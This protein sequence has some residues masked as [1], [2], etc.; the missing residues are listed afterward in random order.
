M[1]NG[2]RDVTSILWSFGKDRAAVGVMAVPQTAAFE[3]E[4]T[5]LVAQA[6]QSVALVYHR[7]GNGAGV[8]WRPDGQI[9]TN[10]HVARDGRVDV[11]LHDGRHYTGIVAA[12]HQTR[13]LAVIKI[14]EEHLPA[15]QIGDSSRVRPGQL[16]LAVGHPAGYR[17]AATLGVVVAAG[18]AATTEGPRTGDFLQADVTIMPGNSGGPLVDAHGHVIGINTMVSGRLALAVPSNAVERFVEGRAASGASG[19]LG[20]TGSFVPLR[21]PDAEFGVVLTAVEEGSPADRAGLIV[22]DVVVAIGG[23][24][25]IDEES[26]PAASLRFV[27]GETVEL[28]VLRGGDPRAFIVVPTERS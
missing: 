18:Q 14:A 27:P 16:A 7:G 4:L 20:I 2:P 8:I 5:A 24:P 3:G 19:Y 25:I 13:D 1:R 26:L 23:A 21:R 10:N 17:D 6:R 15:A 9:V 12:R 22:G 11:V 28:Q